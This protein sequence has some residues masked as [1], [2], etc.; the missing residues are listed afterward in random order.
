MGNNEWTSKTVCA[1]VA[2]GL[3]SNILLGLPFL[4]HNNIIIDH[5]A[6]TAVDK[7]SGFDLLD[8]ASRM[9]CDRLKMSPPKVKVKWMLKYHKAT[10]DE[11][12]MKCAERWE[13]LEGEG[14]LFTAKPM[15]PIALIKLT[16]ERLAAKEKLVK[17]EET[18]KDEYKEIFRPIPHMLPKHDMA[19]INVKEAYK[20]ISNRSYTC[21]KHSKP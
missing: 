1:L 5:T 17:L 6:H 4:V 15:N 19:R 11:L 2:P 20:K 14:E 13:R 8:D 12:K 10:M 16:I 9:P 3:C 7:I 18:I 21:P